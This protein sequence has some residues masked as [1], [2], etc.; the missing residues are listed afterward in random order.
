[1]SGRVTQAPL[2][3]LA[4]PNTQKGRVTQSPLEVLAE[5]STQKGRVTQAVLEVLVKYVEPIVIPCAVTTPAFGNIA[6]RYYI[7]LKD[8]SGVQVALFDDWLSLEIS[9]KVNSLGTY[10]LTFRDNSDSRFNLFELDG[11]IEIYRSIPGMLP[12]ALEF[13]GLHRTPFRGINQN[14]VKVFSSSG[15]DYADLLARTTIAYLGGTVRAD[16]NLIPSETAMKEYAEE[17]C[18]PSA[19]P[20]N[21]RK[22]EADYGSGTFIDAPGVLPGFSIDVDNGAGKLW[23]GSRPAENLL[24]VLIDIANFSGIDYKVEGQALAKFIFKTFVG[25]LGAD[26]TVEG[27]NS[28][29]GKNAA[30]NVP[31][32]FSVPMGSVQNMTYQY[33]R[34]SE[35][36]IIFVLGQGDL[37]TRSVQVSRDETAIADSPWNRRE[38]TRNASGQEFV[39]QLETAGSE[40]LQEL[41]AKEIFIFSPLQQPNSLYGVHYFLGDRV[42]AKYGDVQ[43]NKR[44]VGRRILISGENKREEIVMEFADIPLKVV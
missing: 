28:S 42:T 33:D 17:N 27:L 2:E 29:T 30:G 37:S 22:F 5:P 26:R 21:G 19:T 11:Q 32:V 43:R 8:Q 35:A 40:S 7:R 1:M 41:Q 10:V 24:D 44:I 4:E 3:V 38:V 16:K 34:M 9:S 12:W 18:G 15:F 6:S 31:V 13:E 14:G 23:S 39:Y 25:Q 20:A 36:N